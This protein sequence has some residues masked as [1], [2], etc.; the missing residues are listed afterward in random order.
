[1]RRFSAGLSVVLLVL[2]GTSVAQVRLVG[3]VVDDTRVAVAR[4]GVSIRPRKVGG[5]NPTPAW[6]TVSESDGSF[7]F[8]L[9]GPG[10][11]ELDAA[12]EGYFAL[13]GMALELSEGDNE[14]KI[15]LH[16]L[17]EL[18]ESI[19]VAYSP[20]AIDLAQDVR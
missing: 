4:A 8:E 1:M 2:R 16:H 13:E 11:Y 5:A 17:R 7:G 3:H 19:E 6:Q 18:H 10:A 14:L 20:P 15:V 9:P 12:R